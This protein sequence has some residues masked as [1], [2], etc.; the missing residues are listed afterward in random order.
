MIVGM[1]TDYDNF[2][3]VEIID[4]ISDEAELIEDVKYIIELINSN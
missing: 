2:T 4:L 3:D 1:L